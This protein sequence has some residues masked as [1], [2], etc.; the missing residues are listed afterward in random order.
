[1]FRSATDGLGGN[2]CVSPDARSGMGAVGVSPPPSP[3]GRH[4]RKHPKSHMPHRGTL[5]AHGCGIVNLLPFLLYPFLAENNRCTDCSRCRISEPLP[6]SLY[7]GFPP[8]TRPASERITSAGCLSGAARSHSPRRLAPVPLGPRRAGL[9]RLAAETGG[10][11]TPLQ[12]FG[13]GGRD[14]P[15]M[16]TEKN[17]FPYR[18]RV[19]LC[20]V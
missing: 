7:N 8:G 2:T 5:G 20:P 17:C 13:T 18:R 6:M 16:C 10:R 3:I 9:R 11:V 14:G 19:S 1:M 15:P 4:P 12:A